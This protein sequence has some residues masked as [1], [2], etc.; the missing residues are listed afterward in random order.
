MADIYCIIPHFL[1]YKGLK[2]N[3]SVKIR[4]S[5]QLYLIKH[6]KNLQAL[7]EILI[8]IFLLSKNVGEKKHY[9][10]LLTIISAHSQLIFLMF[11]TIR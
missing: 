6:D 7:C 4:S 10:F 2:R 3:N 1:T 9:S 11:Y 8:E 5:L